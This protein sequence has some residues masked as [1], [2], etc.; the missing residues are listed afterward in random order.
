MF[1]RSRRRAV[2]L[3]AAGS[4]LGGTLIV[5][6]GVASSAPAGAATAVHTHSGFM[7]PVRV[8]GPASATRLAPSKAEIRSRDQAMARISALKAPASPKHTTKADVNTAN[9]GP[10]TTVAAGQKAPI[11]AGPTDFTV[12]K[13]K[14]IPA[15]CATDCAQST[16]NEPSVANAGKDLMEASNWDIATSSNNGTSWS[17]QD[18]YTLFGSGYCCD[19]EVRYDANRDQ[20]IWSGTYAPGNTTNHI[21]VAL[22]SST[23]PTSWCSY[24][25]YPNQFGGT[26]GDV[27]D[28]PKVSVGN[29]DL[30]LTWNE[31]HST[32]AWYQTELVRMDLNAMSTCSSA[33]YSWLARTDVFTFALAGN[34]GPKDVFYWVSNWYISGGTS[35]SQLTIYTWAENSGSYFINQR[36]IN[37][38]TFGTHSCAWCGRLDPRSVSVAI[39]RGGEFRNFGDDFLEV[40]IDAGPS[41]FDA[42][43]YVVYEYF[44]LHSLTYEG[45]DQTYSSSYDFGYPSCASNAEGYIGCSMVDGA[46]AGDAPGGFILL[47][48]NTSPT[49]PW[50]YDFVLAGSLSNQSWGDYVVANPVQPAPGPFETVL[51]NLTSTGVHP[52][53]ITWGRGHDTSGY[54]RWDT[55]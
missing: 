25:F 44:Q 22:A 23:H 14:K 40:A 38:Y 1:K 26:L 19:S 29:N 17:Y 3:A 24:P 21:V 10:Q 7:T 53:A 45:N 16:V 15:A 34:A 47:Q 4:L 36:S 35:G 2:A 28:Y 54:D 48:D 43:N 20:F 9:P 42:F 50:A 52:Y 46:S 27:M 33:G 6:Q 11:T 31:Y 55:K 41:N 8:N 39:S 13:D 37:A 30:Y 5:I 49:Q 12:F 51:W 32:G 18:P